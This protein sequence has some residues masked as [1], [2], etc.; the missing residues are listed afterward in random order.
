MTAHTIILED[1]TKTKAQE[2]YNAC[3][4]AGGIELADMADGSENVAIW[5]RD[6]ESF[7]RVGCPSEDILVDGGTELARK[8]Y[9]ETVEHGTF[10]GKRIAAKIQRLARKTSRRNGGLFTIQYLE[11]AARR[12]NVAIRFN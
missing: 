4:F 9:N 7:W 11:V 6:G 12:L 5:K 10:D 1:G 3:E 8:Y 2:I